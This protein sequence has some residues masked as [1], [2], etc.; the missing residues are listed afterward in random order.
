MKSNFLRFILFLAS[1]LSLSSCQWFSADKQKQQTN[2]LLGEWQLDS[3]RVG[4]DSN[5]IAYLFV[6]M[7]MKDSAGLK[8]RFAQDTLFT[9]SKNN[10]DTNYY[11]YDGD[12]RTMI[13]QDATDQ[14]YTVTTVGESGIALQAKDSSAFFLRKQ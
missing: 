6:A 13:P 1:L 14:V 11:K 4:N 10:V 8:F 2:P 9:I 3:L 12:K 7:E 5:N